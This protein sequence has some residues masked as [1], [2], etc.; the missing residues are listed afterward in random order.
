MLGHV[1][2]QT[3]AARY[4]TY[5]TVRGG[6]GVLPDVAPDAAGLLTGVAATDFDTV[7]DAVA[8]TRPEAIVNCIGIVKQ[9]DEAKDASISIA[10]NSLFPHRLAKLSAAAGSRLVHI[11]TDC[12]FSGAKGLYS[13]DDLPDATDL[14]G[15]T[16][17][18]GEVTGPGALTLRTSIVG[19]EL[20]GAHGL[21]E[22]FLSQE[23]GSV[24]GFRKAIFSGWTTE[25]LATAIAELLETQPELSGLWHVAAAPIDKL[26]LLTLVRDAFGAEIAIE[27]DDALVIDRSLDGSRFV[28]ETGIVAP[29]WADM[30]AR[31]SEGSPSYY[32]SRGASRA[33]G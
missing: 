14:Y 22:W 19:R 25:A 7:V 24:R 18:L 30:I 10:V 1:V 8:R 28:R 4:E 13:E 5:G 2:L 27:P 17:L 12:V 23:G 11:G 33:H 29:E 21:V 32:R 15:R 31:L 9:L 6:T 3:L 20:T 16:K 26:E